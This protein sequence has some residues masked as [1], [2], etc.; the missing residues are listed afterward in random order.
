MVVRRTKKV[1][2][3]QLA[4]AIACLF[5]WEWAGRSSAKI[6]FLIGTPL[7]IFREFKQLLLFESLHYHF[8][9]TSGEAL[10]GLIIGTVVGAGVGLS[11]WYS[12]TAAATARPF[13]ITLGT[14]PIFAFAPLMIVWFGIGFS[15]KVA[16]ATFSTVFVAFNQAY[17]G[18]TLVSQ[19]YVDVLRGMNASRHQIFTKVIIPGSLDWVLSSMRLN[20]GFALLGAFIGEFVASDRGLGYLI[21]RA[22]GL[23]NIPRALAAAVGITVLALSLDF[24]ARYVEGHRHVLVQILS[25]PRSIWRS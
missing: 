15:M 12:E 7:T 11:L 4:V 16:L 5:L 9:V 19:E 22:A 2:G 17:R 8:L 6:F 24:A 18:A 10:I 21:L 20:V 25:V 13:I 1:L 3:L 23:Y 14:L